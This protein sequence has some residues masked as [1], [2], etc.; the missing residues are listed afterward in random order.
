MLDQMESLKWVQK[1]ISSFGGDPD[2][3][4]IF[5]QS[6]GAGSVMSLVTSPMCQK[7]K[8]FH[9]AI[10]QSGGGLRAYGQGNGS[11]PLERALNN[12]LAFFEKYNLSSLEDARAVPAERMLE[13]GAS[14]GG[15]GT[16][17]PT[18]DGKFLMEEP[19]DSMAAHR[20]PDIPML[21]GCTGVEFTRMR[22]E[23]PETLEELEKF[24]E[25]KFG[26]R[27]GEF[28]EICKKQCMEKFGTVTDE[29]IKA[30]CSAEPS[31]EGRFMNNILY[32]M[33]RLDSGFENNFMYFFN[34]TIPGDNAGSYHSSELWFVFETLAKCWRP[35]TGKHYDL[36]R[37]VCNYWTNF[38]KTGN[39]NGT[40]HDGT[41]MPEWKSA[42]P[43]NPFVMF[44]GE[45]YLGEFENCISEI[46]RFRIDYVLNDVLVEKGIL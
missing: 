35:F 7:Q 6:A 31:L 33:R 20:Y 44:L 41:P 34:P 24:A 27:A 21:F 18:V 11:I 14:N 4:T 43:D 5:G 42:A 30:V 29:T 10:M 16:W 15:L 45:E 12:G 17:A 3:V 26:K 28:V 1:N 22:K 40:D 36:A 25:Q 32:L 13:M 19:S 38:A 9:K 23:L 46:G 39:P 37:I 8:L 2:N